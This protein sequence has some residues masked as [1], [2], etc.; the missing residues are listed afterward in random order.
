MHYSPWLH[1]SLVPQSIVRRVIA[2][3]TE[4]AI[5]DDGRRLLLRAHEKVYHTNILAR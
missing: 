1:N 2:Y 5:F 3:S 4:M